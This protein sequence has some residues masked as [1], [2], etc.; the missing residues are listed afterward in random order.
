VGAIGDGTQAD[1][2][3]AL[4]AEIESEVEYLD[5]TD[6]RIRRERDTLRIQRFS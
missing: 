2:N 5:G 1:C 4:V 6:A 3:R